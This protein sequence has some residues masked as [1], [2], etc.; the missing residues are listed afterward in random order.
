[1]VQTKA[2][3]KLDVGSISKDIIAEIDDTYDLGAED[4]RWSTIYV[5]LA[6]LT[7]MIIGSVYLG[8]TIDGWLY[9]NA[10]TYVNGSLTTAGNVTSEY[11]IGDGSMLTGLNYTVDTDTNCTAEGSCPL[12]T[13]DSELNYTIDTDT[14]CTAEGSCPL[15]TYDSE[16]NY[17]VDTDTHFP[18][19]RTDLENQSGILGINYTTSDGRYSNDTDTKWIMESPYLY[20]DSDTAYFNASQLEVIYYNASSVEVITGSAVGTLGDIQ[21][22]NGVFYNVTE[23]ASDYEL[24]VNFTGIDDFTALIVRHKS[25]I[26][27]GHLATIQMWDYPNSRWEGYGH[28][29]ETLTSDII[30]LGVYDAADHI[31]DGVVQVRFSQTEVGLNHIHYFDWVA[32][33]KGF[34]VPPSKEVDPYSVHRDGTT[35]LTDNWNAGS[36]NITTSF[37][38]GSATHAINA[39]NCSQLN[40]QLGS[41]Y[42]AN[43]NCSVSLSCANITYNEENISHNRLPTVAKLNVSNTFTEIQTFNE[44][45]TVNTTTFPTNVKAC[46]GNCSAS[47]IVWNGTTLIIR[48][49]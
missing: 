25:D 37:F 35:P 41:Y 21:T 7:S 27:D 48:V 19:N 20:N 11:F 3:S 9:I 49:T 46:F 38:I 8:N 26:D 33:S 17:T 36:F 5:V 2:T 28:L 32:I 18:Y 22:Y 34:G 12:I 1:M 45:M 6:V 4:K 44:N 42:L 24:R 31:E 30:T 16:L 39:D 23:A 40:D 13:Y 15:I 14:N 29:I 47:Y 43:T 10:S